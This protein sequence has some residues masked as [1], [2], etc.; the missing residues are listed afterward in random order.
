MLSSLD[1]M[2]KNRSCHNRLAKN[3]VIKCL[4]DEVFF[5]ETFEKNYY[6]LQNISKNS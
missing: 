4:H 2:K 6:L 3:P 5:T 1:I